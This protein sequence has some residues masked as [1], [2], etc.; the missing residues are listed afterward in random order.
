M[1]E[2]V[3]LLTIS[4]EKI[5]AKTADVFS[6]LGGWILAVCSLLLSFLGDEK[7]AFIAVG[8]AI[9]FDMFWGVC[10]AIKRK[11]FLLSYLGRETFFKVLIYGST[12][13]LALQIERS[14]NDSWGIVT[15]VLCVLAAI[16]EVW[17][18]CAH[19]LIIKP[20]FPFIRLFRK[21]LAGEI[22]S[23]MKASSE[24]IENIMNDKTDNNAGI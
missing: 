11:K 23:K 21:H 13:L 1:N 15:R 5:I 17:S 10:S 3:H 7:N 4:G 24:E 22:A 6:T 16:C 14:L 20:N 12:L 18:A 19:I 2:I 8:L 9:L